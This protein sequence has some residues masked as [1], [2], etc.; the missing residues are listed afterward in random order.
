MAVFKQISKR[1]GNRSLFHIGVVA[2][3]L[4]VLSSCTQLLFVPMRQYLITPD[5][6]DI[7]YSDVSV[8]S[9]DGVKLHGWY[10][11]A[12]EKLKGTIVFL[13]G[14][15]ENISTHLA[16]VYWLPSK[17]Y[18]VFLF[19]YRG[20]G[21]SEGEVD[22]EGSAHDVEAMIGF[23]VKNKTSEGK[24]IV[25]GHSFGGSIG[26]Y[27]VANSS[28]KNDIL[29]MVTIGAF[30][31][32]RDVTQDALSRSWLTWLFQW[33]LSFTIN[34]DF[35]PKQYVGKISPVPLLIMHSEMDEI[36]S[37]YHADV[38]FKQANQPKTLIKVSGDHNHVFNFRENRQLLLDYLEKIHY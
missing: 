36:V 5:K 3:C 29:T 37:Y 8:L 16:T 33:P 32:Y 23:A 31:D 13:H 20:Y 34:N 35:S 7:S 30:S 28:Y 24:L 25:M 18:E 27:A 21:F 26:I 1:L 38:L 19:D 12:T 2:A 10:L 14:N 17:G 11:P 6:I 9:Q 22:L 15:G 4:L